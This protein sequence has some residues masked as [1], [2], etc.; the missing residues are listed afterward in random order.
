ML[1]LCSVE[2]NGTWHGLSKMPTTQG[3]TG[4]IAAIAFVL[5]VKW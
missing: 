5:W 1:L 2:A 4:R 3:R